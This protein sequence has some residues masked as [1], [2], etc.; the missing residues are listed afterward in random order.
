MNPRVSRKWAGFLLITLVVGTFLTPYSIFFEKSVASGA[1]IP[2]G[3]IS[4]TNLSSELRAYTGN[5]DTEFIGDN[6]WPLDGCDEVYS[7][8]CL[9][10]PGALDALGFDE[11]AT[12]SPTLELSAEITGITGDAFDLTVRIT[13][14]HM[15][16]T[17]PGNF[18]DMQFG[19]WIKKFDEDFDYDSPRL[20]S[21]GIPKID[22]Y[23]EEEGKTS[24]TL[25]VDSLDKNSSYSLAFF[26]AYDVSDVDGNNGPDGGT[27]MYVFE[28][29]T[30]SDQ[31]VVDDKGDYDD[32]P[33][34]T[35]TTSDIGDQW[36][37]WAWNEGLSLSGCLLTLY[38]NT[39]YPLSS[40]ILYV[41][42]KFFDGMANWSLSSIMY[43]QSITDSD[44]EVTD[45]LVGTGWKL[46][47][48]FSN[49]FFIL[50]LVYLSISIILGIENA[51]AKKSIATVV[52]VA[53]L[54]NFSLLF[55]QI[56]LDS[57]NILAR[58]FYN[59][60][61]VTGTLDSGISASDLPEVALSEAIAE[62]F[63]V[64]NIVGDSKTMSS[65]KQ[66]T[67]KFGIHAMLYLMYVMGTVVNLAAAWVF[68]TV[69]MQFALRIVNVWFSMIF[70]PFAFFTNTNH[71]LKHLKV[72]GWDNWLKN[73]LC[74][75]F[76]APLFLFF[77]FL[78]MQLIQADFLAI[79]LSAQKLEN[80]FFLRMTG[81]ML[82]FV[83]IIIM[84]WKAK[85]IAKELGCEGAEM[86]TKAIAGAALGAATGGAAFAMRQTVGRAGSVIQNSETLK[87]MQDRGGVL[88][89]LAKGTRSAGG[90][91]AKQSF[92]LRN[93]G[94]GKAAL[95]ATG[96]KTGSVLFG[97]DA[98]LSLIHI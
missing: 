79:I 69:G 97:K 74:W 20:S 61:K 77:I 39:V 19:V 50:I 45:T 57:S 78:I 40:G 17:D 34:A 6:H 62:G 63:N 80:D 66:G 3:P 8:N 89:S 4:I 60:I 54:I 88:G 26:G 2:T 87:R 32:V 86:A 41:T 21:D 49:I 85:D 1:E 18:D 76:F 72:F 53:L 70:A 38:A 43:Q 25:H 92:D 35:F 82:Q 98:G 22:V 7:D 48:D 93:T 12:P 37:C 5:Y 44:G 28:K 15:E 96:V 90:Y 83:I 24:F 94:Y 67:T 55:C 36:F 14:N 68:F 11:D 31:D 27:P 95:G 13:E 10:Y 23:K 64:Q 51:H 56:V 81:I 58:V 9:T 16:F 65:L 46:V 47:R 73:F 29:I 75:C 33:N 84:L 30:T 59:Q 71:K 42:G 52:V 91:G